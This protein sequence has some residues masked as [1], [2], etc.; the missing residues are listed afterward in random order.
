MY[1]RNRKQEKLKEILR[2]QV[3]GS[4]ENVEP[5]LW[6]CVVGD[7]GKKKEMWSITLTYEWRSVPSS[8]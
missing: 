5:G 7:S 3:Q 1:T 6:F 4:A 2:D 8:V